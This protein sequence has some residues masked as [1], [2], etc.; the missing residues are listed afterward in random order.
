VAALKVET[1]ESKEALTEFIRFYD[2]VYE[3][4]DARWPEDLS[5]KLSILTTEN[6]FAEGQIMRPLVVREGSRILARVL[7]V[8]NER[9]NQHWQERLGHICWFEALPDARQATKLLLDEACQWLQSQGIRAARAGFARQ[10][11]P[12]VI[13]DYESLPPRILRHNPAYYHSFLKDAGFE[14]EKGFVDYKIEVRPE[15]VARWES[16]LEAARCSGYE[17]LPLRELPPDLCVSDFTATFNDTFKAHWGWTPMTE[18]EISFLFKILKPLGTLDTSVLAYRDGQPVGMLYVTPERASK[19][20]LKSSRGLKDSER[21][22]LLAIG[23]CESARGQGVNLAMA[24]YGFLELV[25]R[26]A[27]YLSYTLVVDDNWPSRRTAEKL[28]A[29]IC[30]NYLVYRRNFRQ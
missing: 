24:G 13:D 3:Y 18:E 16:A 23:V 27:K 5:W 25:R 19:V 9:Y 11:N 21:L 20:V 26:G 2:Q 28:G 4:R 30:A 12:F 8:V 15:L 1:L 7:A 22:N 14:S 6:P 17:I 10:E 29:Y